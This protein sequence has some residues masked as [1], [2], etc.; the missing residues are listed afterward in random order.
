MPRDALIVYGTTII[1]D[2]PEG[3]VPVVPAGWDV[4]CENA[5]WVTLWPLGRVA[6]PDVFAHAW[7]A[8]RDTVDPARGCWV[9]IGP[10]ALIDALKPRVQRWWERLADLRADNGAIATGIKA[11]WSGGSVALRARMAG[12]DDDDAEASR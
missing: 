5:R 7:L 9:V 11:Q 3:P 12:F 4:T 10:R 6:R 1:G 8:V 2:S